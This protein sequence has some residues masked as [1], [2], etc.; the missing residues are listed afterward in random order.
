GLLAKESAIVLLAVLI[1]ADLCTEQWRT[2]WT[3]LLQNYL[4]FFVV[5]A[6]YLTIRFLV[7]NQIGVS[8]DVTFFKN[9]NL[10]GRIFTMSQAFIRYFELLV[11][12]ANLCTDYDFTVIP[13][14]TTINLPVAL[15]LLLIGGIF[16]I[17]CWLLPR[18]QFIAFAILFFFITIS[19]VSNVIFPTGILMTERAL[20]LPVASIC[21]LVGGGLDWLAS[22]SKR[23]QALAITIIGLL[24]VA[25]AIR[26]YYRNLDWLDGFNYARALIHSAPNNPKG[27]V[28]LGVLYNQRGMYQEA[29]ATLKQAVTIAPDKAVGHGRLG[30]FYLQ[31]GRFDEAYSELQRAISIYS[32]ESYLQAALGRVYHQRGE[33]RQ[34][35]ESFRQ[36]IVLAP[37]D[38]LLYEQLG[39]ILYQLGDRSGALLEFQRA[40]E[41]KPDLATVHTNLG[42]LLKS[43][44]ENEKALQH[45]H[46]AT[47]LEPDNAATHNVYGTTLLNI[48]RL[49][50]AE[51]EF[52]TAIRHDSQ[53]VEAH[54]NLGIVY[55]EMGRYQ[56]A[57][58]EFETA[59]RINPDYLN[60]RRNLEKLQ[61]LQGKVE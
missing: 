49:A 25:A 41:L 18:V 28:I 12:P 13:K 14:V 60:A 2:Q 36:A 37:Q 17:G 47:E 34:A 55:I 27:Y 10:A 24:L 7:L 44:G 29:E 16:A 43:L 38:A 56:D 22:R 50:E 32:R 45:L 39:V 5:V 59:L 35:I 54:N 9:V 48:G 51:I 61:A 1:L 57:R 3:K 31:R 26:D 42:L 11:W 33:Y 52:A 53:F 46:R 4:G 19:I 21:L 6:I 30:E 40:L 15:S 23:Q 58:H 20:Y 8:G